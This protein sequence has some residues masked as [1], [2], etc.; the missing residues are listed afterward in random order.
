MVMFPEGCSEAVEVVLESGGVQ[1]VEAW[2]VTCG[3]VGEG[4][5]ARDSS[6]RFLSVQGAFQRPV[7]GSN[8]RSAMDYGPPFGMIRNLARGY[9]QVGLKQ[10]YGSRAGHAV[11]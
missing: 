3:D 10:G 11:T 4:M 6:D 5:R 2:A 9:S 7:A 8:S 1:Q